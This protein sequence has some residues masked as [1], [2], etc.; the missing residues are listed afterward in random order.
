MG[1]TLVGASVVYS[2]VQRAVL[3]QGVRSTATSD[4]DRVLSR[5]EAGTAPATAVRGT[6]TPDGS[7]AVVLSADGSKV[8]ASWG[9]PSAVRAYLTLASPVKTGTVSL[10]GERYAFETSSGT[11]TP[12]PVPTVTVPAQDDSGKTSPSPSSEPTSGA[13][14]GTTTGTTD[15]SGGSGADSGGT[16]GGSDDSGGSGSGSGRQSGKGGGGGS[17]G[18]GSDDVGAPAPGAPAPDAGSASVRTPGPVIHLAAARPDPSTDYVV[19]AARSLA[20]NAVTERATLTTLGVVIPILLLVMAATTWLVVGRSLRPVE[21]MRLEVEGITA[22][23]LSNRIPGQGGSDEI[24][25]LATTLNEMLDRLDDSA[26][27][28]RRFVSD[29]SHELRSPLAVMRQ[30]A[31]VQR[32]YPGR[33]EPELLAD[34]VLTEGQR[35]ADLVQGM[36]ILARADEGG[37]EPAMQAVD[38]DDI[39]LGEA[40]RL[41]SAGAVTVDATNVTAARVRG[42]RGMLAQVVRNL[43]DNAARHAAGAVALSLEVADGRVL[44]AVDDDGAGVPAADR[45][46]VFSRFVRLDEARAR[47]AGGSG[48]GLAIVRSLVGVHDGE[49]RVADS[50]LGGARFEV[51]L[52]LLDD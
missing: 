50:A 5:L 39:V 19:A 18:G 43:A 20:A 42:D 49:V 46:R 9:D 21:Q 4:A 2:V 11:F 17:G 23:R 7:V 51:S 28:Q 41:R 40:A 10:S 12:T 26:K 8:L 37:L 31:E 16:S 24:A 22:A 35:L 52:P 3:E 38:V 29:A 32:A 1:V 44:L 36:L 30:L 34:T 14:T 25:R 6:G 13:G 15:D 45:D 27:S 48:L 47:E 33:I